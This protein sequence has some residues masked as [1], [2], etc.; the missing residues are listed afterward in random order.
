MGNGDKEEGLVH[1]QEWSEDVGLC[2]A[3]LVEGVRYH[4]N[5]GSYAAHEEDRR[6]G[7]VGVQHLD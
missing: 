7:D 4:E 2:L 1:L 6:G 3:V 5:V